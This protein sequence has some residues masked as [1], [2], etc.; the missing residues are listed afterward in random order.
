MVDTL[1][2]II[3]DTLDVVVKNDSAVDCS[4]DTQLVV[5]PYKDF[6]FV[7]EKP[8]DFDGPIVREVTF[9][10]ASWNF[11]LLFAVIIM[12]VINKFLI[13]NK[14]E[15]IMSFPFQN[16]N[17]DKMIRESY[18]CFSTMSLLVIFS[19]AILISMMVQKLYLIYGGN[20]ILH[21]N[22]SF[23]TDILVAVITFFILNYLLTSFFSRLFDMGSLLLIHVN[24]HISLMSVCNVLLIPIMMILL[25]YP[26][27]F[28]LIIGFIIVFVLFLVRI[29]I[30][31][32]EIRK[33]FKL[34]FVNIFLYLCTVE[35][36][37]IMVI[38]K[39]IF[40]VI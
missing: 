33:L 30:F 24:M 40:G 11:M 9:I 6:S 28:F 7:A 32:I 22:I 4:A 36:L 1:E 19:F 23:F 25:F 15:S 3:A 10:S 20:H 38:A 13:P 31:F 39:M 16:G 34:S 5:N 21:S 12:V 26:Y 18:S 17:G 8:V 37:P 29:V 14:S 2:Y 27:K 35:I